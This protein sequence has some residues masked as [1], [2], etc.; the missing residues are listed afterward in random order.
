MNVTI[1]GKSALVSG[2]NRG[3]GKAITEAL[4]DNGAKKVYAGARKVASLK[5]LKEKYGGRL[6]PVELDVTK[7]DT[8]ANAAK[9]AADVDILVNNAGV[10]VPGN[11]TYGNILDSL[12]ANLEVNLWGLVKLTNVFFNSLKSRESAAIVSVSSVVGLANMPAASGYSASKAAVH[13]IVQGLRGELKGSNVLVCGVYPGPIDTDMAKGFEMEKDS[14]E[15]VAKNVINAIEKGIE[16]VFP[17]VMSL[18]VGQAYASNPKGV[19]VQFS[20]IL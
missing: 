18:Q 20:G 4:L 3:I 16:D 5:E 1:K 14:P 6:I 10:L 17:D 2:A 7:D 8:I 12:H 15:N 13:S 19:E 9:T 11:F